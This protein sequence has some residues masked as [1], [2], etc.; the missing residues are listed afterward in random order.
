M[1]K[2]VARAALVAALVSGLPFSASLAQSGGFPSIISGVFQVASE[3][4]TLRGDSPLASG[5]LTFQ[6]PSPAGV[7]VFD[8]ERLGAAGPLGHGTTLFPTAT[9]RSVDTGS[10]ILAFP[11]GASN[12]KNFG[13]KR[14]LI[15]SPKGFV[16]VD[17]DSGSTFFEQKMANGSYSISRVESLD[18]RVLA[19]FTYS[20]GAALPSVI[21]LNGGEKKITIDQNASGNITRIS[22]DG[23]VATYSYTSSGSSNF[24]SEVKVD[25]VT[26]L[27][28][29]WQQG[30]P[31][32]ALNAYGET[33][34]Y[35]FTR[36][37]D[38]PAKVALTG[39]SAFDGTVSTIQYSVANTTVR[40]DGVPYRYDWAKNPV[41]GNTYARSINRADRKL[42]STKVDPVTGRVL[43]EEDEFGGVTSYVWDS[44]P[45][46]VPREIK[47]SDGTSITNTVN[48]NDDITSTLRKSSSGMTTSATYVYDQARRLVKYEVKDSAGESSASGSYTYSGAKLVPDSISSNE[49]TTVRFSPR[50]RMTSVSRQGQTFTATASDGGKRVQLTSNGVPVQIDRSASSNGVYTMAMN[51]PLVKVNSK[52]DP[53]RGG[54]S[55]ESFRYGRSQGGSVGPMAANSLNSS[56]MTSAF[57]V[58]TGATWLPYVR[59]QSSRSGSPGNYTYDVSTTT[60]YG[61]RKETTTA[62]QGAD[63]SCSMNG[64]CQAVPTGLESSVEPTPTP[65][66]PATPT[67]R[68]PVQPTKTPVHNDTPLSPPAKAT[69]TPITVNPTPPTSGGC[70]VLGDSECC[71]KNFPKGV[72]A[73]CEEVVL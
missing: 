18:K 36:R 14:S 24:L 35:A 46:S 59:Q 58:D 34:M 71:L 41:T 56:F 65:V 37:I 68:P 43:L 9:A 44:R 8:S 4:G 12:Y 10:V 39:I 49:R 61:T 38:N 7:A 31:V 42:E 57:A 51:A 15:S 40:V 53:L 21:S 32:S 3:G 73:V 29:T 63:G 27:K 6:I 2:F 17:P 69:K 30:L 64:S 33:E 19:T 67:P 11:N 48:A 54:R 70:C 60:A 66:V 20:A 23:M 55:Y 25:G 52:S 1:N 13:D 72:C 28:L 16:L 5:S 47:L 50:G 26:V 22:A 62:V 45:S